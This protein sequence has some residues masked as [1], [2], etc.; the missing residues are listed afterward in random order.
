MFHFEIEI[1]LLRIRPK[2]DLFDDHFLGFGLDLL[3][4]LLLLVF[5]FRVINDLADRRISIRRYLN[6]IQPL[7]LREFYSLLNGINI[8]FN[9]FAYNPY[10]RSVYPLVDFVRLFSLRPPSEGP[11]VTGSAASGIDN[12]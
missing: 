12:L 8:T 2:P 5:E 11:V 3:L 1:M 10:P 6:K 4:L 7:L 9:V